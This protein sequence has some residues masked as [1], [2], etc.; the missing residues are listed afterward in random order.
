MTSPVWPGPLCDSCCACWFSCG[1]VVGHSHPPKTGSTCGPG[2]TRTVTGKH[3]EPE[4]HQLL[5]S[6]IIQ[7]GSGTPMKGTVWTGAT[8]HFNLQPLSTYYFMWM[9]PPPRAE[10]RLPAAGPGRSP[11]VCLG[12]WSSSD[13]YS[14]YKHSPWMCH[15]GWTPPP[16]TSCPPPSPLRPPGGRLRPTATGGASVW[17]PGLQPRWR[18]A[19]SLHKLHP[20][21]TYKIYFFSCFS[22]IRHKKFREIT[23][24]G[25]IYLIS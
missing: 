21:A 2:E 10:P 17:P 18:Q 11:D 9:H 20:V 12:T 15:R 16:T 8:L 4:K 25:K 5:Y 14:H 19:G 13:I 3:V 1:R 24:I 22:K 7:I 23:W 6:R